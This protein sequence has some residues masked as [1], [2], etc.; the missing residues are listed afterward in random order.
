MFLTSFFEL[1]A[2]NR[3]WAAAAPRAGDV[4]EFLWTFAR[5]SLSLRER[6]RV[7]GNGALAGYAQSALESG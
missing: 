3:A 1:T 4:S 5:C 7:R 2:G 6:V